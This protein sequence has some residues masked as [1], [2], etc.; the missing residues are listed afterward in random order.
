MTQEQFNVLFKE[1]VNKN[2]PKDE[3]QIAKM[4]SEYEDP[5]GKIGINEIAIFAYMES[6]KYVNNLVYALLS[7]LI[8]NIQKE[9]QPN[10]PTP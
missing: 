10:N 1:A 3:K 8:S 4:F 7:E 2:L 5:S 6:V 9:T